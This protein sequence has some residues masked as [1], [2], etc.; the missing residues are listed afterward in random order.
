MKILK[1]VLDLFVKIVSALL[2]ILIAGIVCV[3]LYELILRNVFNS[4]FRASTEIC[5][6]LFI[7]I[8]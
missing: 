3:M 7:F 5:G 8:D 2:I 4:S 6:F 1:Q